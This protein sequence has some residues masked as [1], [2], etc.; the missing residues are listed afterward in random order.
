MTMTKGHRYA[1][2]RFTDDIQRLVSRV[3]VR[4]P[5]RSQVKELES[6]RPLPDDPL[7]VHGDLAVH[8]IRCEVQIARPSD[9]T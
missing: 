5:A 2:D 3:P 9:S 1:F 8:R 7:P 4:K 6:G